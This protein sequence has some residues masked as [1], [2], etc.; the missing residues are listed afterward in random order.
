[1]GPGQGLGQDGGAGGSRGGEETAAKEKDRI[2]E[3]MR[4]TK[5]YE[6]CLQTFMDELNRAA[7]ADEAAKAGRLCVEYTG[8]LFRVLG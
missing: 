5:T 3:I 4:M 6:Q 1:M 8:N 7:T 2:G